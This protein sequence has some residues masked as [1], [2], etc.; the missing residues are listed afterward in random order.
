MPD[1]TERAACNMAGTAVFKDPSVYIQALLLS[2][3]VDRLLLL[4]ICEITFTK[5]LPEVAC[6]E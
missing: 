6:N 1:I 3:G 2:A 4:Y 5:I